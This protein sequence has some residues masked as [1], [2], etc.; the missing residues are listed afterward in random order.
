[1]FALL[2]FTYHGDITNKV[3]LKLFD[4]IST[5]FAKVF[6]ET[7]LTVLMLIVAVTTMH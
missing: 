3:P 4:M 6:V 7:L 1:M 5:Y 2:L